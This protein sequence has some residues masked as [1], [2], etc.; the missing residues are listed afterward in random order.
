MIQRSV[1][2]LRPVTGETPVFESD[3]VSLNGYLVHSETIGGGLVNDL[4]V[5]DF[6]D[7]PDNEALATDFFNFLKNNTTTEEFKA[8]FYDSQKLA[9]SLN[10]FY[11]RTVNAG[12]RPSTKEISMQ[13]TGSTA[14][15]FSS[16]DFISDKSRSNRKTTVMSFINTGHSYYIP[17]FI[18]TQFDRVETSDFDKYH[19]DCF[20]DEQNIT[21]TLYKNFLKSETVLV[22]N[23]ENEIEEYKSFVGPTTGRDGTVAFKFK[24][25]KHVVKTNEVAGQAPVSLVFQSPVP[26]AQTIYMLVSTASTATF[27]IDFDLN[28]PSFP[29]KQYKKFD[30][31]VGDTGL[32]TSVR[33]F[34]SFKL[35]AQSKITLFLSTA[36][37]GEPRGGSVPV[38]MIPDS[39]TFDIINVQPLLSKN[40]LKNLNEVEVKRAKRSQ[41]LLQCFVDKDFNDNETEFWRNDNVKVVTTLGPNVSVSSSR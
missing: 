16:V 25:N 27:G 18:D 3:L 7:N 15:T 2:L 17:V 24:A 22:S 26:S 13:L 4:D 10:D 21:E 30:L 14:H 36:V 35:K 34:D 23:P 5:R 1:I 33:I 31:K 38:I 12:V 37:V 6:L 39:R 20:G 41:K 11:A 29:N 19:Q 32:T 40:V 9:N 8:I 28:N